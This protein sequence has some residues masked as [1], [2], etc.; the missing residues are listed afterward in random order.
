MEGE[1]EG[2]E[3]HN[4]TKGDTPSLEL[5]HSPIN[6]VPT[7]FSFPNFG[8]KISKKKISE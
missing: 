1:R 2:L 7:F 6:V 8:K 4:G 3:D 5:I